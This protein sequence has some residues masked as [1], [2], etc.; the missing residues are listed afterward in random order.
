MAG[1]FL[2]N[3]GSMKGS[4]TKQPFFAAIYDEMLIILMRVTFFIMKKTIAKFI[5]SI[6][7]IP[8]IH[9]DDLVSCLT[10]N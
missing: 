6:Y 7:V 8:V 4:C 3:F 5:T 9:H 1:P 10:R 2:K